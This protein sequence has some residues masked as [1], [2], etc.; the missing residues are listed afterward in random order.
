MATYELTS[1]QSVRVVSDGSN[2]QIVAAAGKESGVNAQTGTSYTITT[3]DREKLVTFSNSATVAISLAQANT[4]T[5]KDGW[6]VEVE[7]TGAGLSTVTPA[8][9]TIGGLATLVL[10]RGQRAK[11]ISDGT[12]YQ[13][14]LLGDAVGDVKFGY[15]S[16][17]PQGWLVEDGSTIGSTASSAD[18]AGPIFEALYHKYWNDISDT[19]AAVST[20][21]GG[22]AAADFA[23]DKTLTIPD[24]DKRVPY[25][26][27]TETTGETIGAATVS[28]TGTVGV[29]GA[30]T[31]TAAQVPALTYT[32][33]MFGSSSAGEG[34]INNSQSAGTVNDTTTGAVTTNAGGGSHTHS[35]GTFTGS[36]SSVEQLGRV[37][38]WYI[39]Y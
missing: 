20:G 35:G 24:N 9:S 3:G 10:T 18:N 34:A 33:N 27:G 37:I 32:V 14:V 17:A 16:T 39:K 25:G 28:A 11:I 7:N 15:G 6:W 23:A 21:R 36:G 13:A 1:G 2:Y 30:T 22:S 5:F 19:Y 12:N 4:T 31:L 38:Y 8:T 26:A 29:S